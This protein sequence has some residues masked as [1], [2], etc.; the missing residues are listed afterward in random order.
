MRIKVFTFLYNE[1]SHLNGKAIERC[2]FMYISE[3]FRS[4]KK[5][6]VYDEYESY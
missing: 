5:V 3:E 2:A 6:R 1:E 4:G